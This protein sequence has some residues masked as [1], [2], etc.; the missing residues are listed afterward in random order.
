M[1]NKMKKIV[2]TLAILCAFSASSLFA[3]SPGSSVTDID[4]SSDVGDSIFPVAIYVNYDVYNFPTIED[5]PLRFTVA[6]SGGYTT[7]EI[8]QNPTDGEPDW[9]DSNTY[10]TYGAI[11]S[12]YSFKFAQAF[13][14]PFEIPGSLDTSLSFDCMYERPV[15]EASYFGDLY[16]GDSIETVFT[17]SSGNLKTS[18]F[19][20]D[21]VGTPDLNGNM[22]LRAFSLN[23]SATYSNS[24]NEFDY[25]FTNSAVLAPAFGIFNTGGD[26]YGGES[27]YYK[28]A[29]SFY[30]KKDIYGKR[31]TDPVT[32]ADSRLYNIW[33]SDSLSYRYLKGDKVPMFAQS[34]D[35]YR[36]GVDNYLKL[37]I[38]G[39]QF[40]TGDTYPY[41]YIAYVDT[42]TWGELNNCTTGYTNPTSDIFSHY[43]KAY[44]DMRIIGI[45]HFSTY[46]TWTLDNDSFISGSGDYTEFS[47]WVS[48]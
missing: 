9:S 14:V 21:L 4:Q 6:L 18:I 26:T 12:E 25:S 33:F 37:N 47:F 1:L 35:N 24:I 20:G 17:D 44:F 3:I 22:Y 34:H 46:Y 40:I 42:L 15:T 41:G 8:T 43:Y 11:F 27:E 19:D 16:D 36:H 32:G 31:Y 2:V 13:P 28:L 23:A 45:I 48:I 5:M 7:E 30:I 29:S 39:P 10:D 38:Y